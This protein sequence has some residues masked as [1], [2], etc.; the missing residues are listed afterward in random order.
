L[1]DIGLLPQLSYL[2]YH[3]LSLSSPPRH[4]LP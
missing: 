2:L 1:K 4:Y 3:E